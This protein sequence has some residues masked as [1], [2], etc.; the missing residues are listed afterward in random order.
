MNYSLTF[1]DKD[2]SLY[3]LVYTSRQ[4][5]EVFSYSSR[6]SD[7]VYIWL[8]DNLQFIEQRF[9]SLIS[10]NQWKYFSNPY[11]CQTFILTQQL[12]DN[13]KVYLL[14]SCSFA[15]QLFAYEHVAKIFVAYL[16]SNQSGIFSKW[17][18]AFPVIRGVYSDLNSLF[19]QLD[20]DITT[21][22]ELLPHRQQ[23]QQKVSF[24]EILMIYLTF[25]LCL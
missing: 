14:S 20:F 9:Q 22:I 24:D 17:T 13:P 12:Q 16:Y 2:Q 6:K 11:D 19:K 23:Q 15:E 3:S 25:F 10:P 18:N 5:N 8:D 4:S 21:N 7:R 1:D